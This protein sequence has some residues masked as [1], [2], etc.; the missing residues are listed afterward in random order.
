MT[1][2]AV[3]QPNFLPWLGYFDK[4]ASADVF[5]LIDD[6][7]YVK[8]SVCNRSKIKNNMG[9]AVWLTIPVRIS[10]GWDQNMNEIEM[11]YAQKWPVKVL[12]QIRGAYANA[13]Y[14][15]EH[16]EKIKDLITPEYPSL[17]ALNIAL[18]R[19]VKDVIG[20]AT[21]VHVASELNENFGTKNDRNMNICKY[22]KGDTYLSGAGAKKYN[23][24]ALFRNHRISLR[25][26]EFAHP[27]YPQI[28]GPFLP[29]LSVID[30]LFNCGPDSRGYV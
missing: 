7:Q 8:Q 24:E 1:T 26:H 18:I 15:K 25:Y 13:P 2:L 5:V 30:L 3:H 27:V 19:Y 16:F 28:N 14:F 29:N 17:A 9:E 4:M 21:K 10:K 20:I 11:D 22:F 23:D 12:N 6:V